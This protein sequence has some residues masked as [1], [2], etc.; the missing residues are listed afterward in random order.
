VLVEAGPRE[1]VQSRKRVERQRLALERALAGGGAAL[2]VEAPTRALEPLLRGLAPE[3]TVVIATHDLAQAARL[4]DRT[5]L[6]A[7]DGTLLDEGETARLL[8]APT[9]DRAEAYLRAESGSDA[10]RAELD[11]LESNLRDEGGLVLRVLRGALN[12][13]AQRDIRLADDAIALRREVHGRYQEIGDAIQ[14]LL[15]LQILVASDLRLALAILHANIALERMADDGATIARL[16]KLVADVEPDPL[17]LQSLE[18]TGEGAEEMIRVALDAFMK[19]NLE[20]A[21]SLAG[22]LE[23]MARSNHSFVERAVE[24]VGEPGRREWLLRMMLVSG[25]LE[26]IGGQAVA[27]GEQAAYLVTGAARKF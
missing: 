12:S 5:A 2:L 20:V 1:F 24:I 9:D 27:V 23:P 26:R 7:A 8:A 4:A 18:G 11:R 17:L 15:A 21:R 19:R 3:H 25:A 16:M 13:L 6:F 22:L 14:G 10:A